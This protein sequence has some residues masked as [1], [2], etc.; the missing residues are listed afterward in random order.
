MLAFR[1]LA[2]VLLAAPCLASAQQE[3][4]FRWPNGARAAVNLAYDD[5]LDSQLD[6]AIPALERHGFRGSFY[7]TLANPSVRAR[8]EDWRAAAGRGHELGNHTLFHACAKSLPQREWVSA[9]LDLDTITVDELKQHIVLANAM[10]HAIDGREERT[11]TAPCGDL[12]AAGEYYLD[13]VKDQFV[14][15]KA[16]AGGVTPDMRTLDPYLVGVDAPAGATGA[17]LIETVRQ[18]AALGTMA[19]LTFHGVGGDY[20]AVSAEAHEE[21]LRHL[22]DNR[23]LYWVDTFL[24]I[25][26]YVKASRPANEENGK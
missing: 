14:A 8:L 24:N 9:W 11:F 6:Q 1:L 4:P 21:L 7:L 5:A 22:A 20:L 25:M 10:L 12:Y 15:I 3:L 17:E 23:D 18:A 13:A 19:N 16:R 2:T 26:Q